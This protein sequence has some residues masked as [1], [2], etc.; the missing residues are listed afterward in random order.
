M[1]TFQRLILLFVF[2]LP[3]FLPGTALADYAKTYTRHRLH[4]NNQYYSDK[5]SACTA[6]VNAKRASYPGENIQQTS[7]SDTTVQAQGWSAGYQY[8]SSGIT[9]YG[10]CNGV[11]SEWGNGICT[12]SCVAPQ[13]LQ[14]DGTCAVPPPPPCTEGKVV[15]DDYTEVNKSNAVGCLN[16]CEYYVPYSEPELDC[17]FASG[18][19]GTCKYLYHTVFK[20][21]GIEC[22]GNDALPPPVD[23]SPP[24]CEACK[25]ME[26]GGAWGTVNG[27]NTCVPQGS[28][29][30]PPVTT[31]IPPQVKTETPPPT[32]ENPNPTPVTTTTNSNVNVTITSNA[33]GDPVI[34]TETTNADGS[35]T[36]TSATKGQ[37]CAAN[38][39]AE[40]CGG[41]GVGKN[42]SYNGA[43]NPDGTVNVQCDGDAIQCAI[44]KQSAELNC[45]L[46]PKQEEVDAY[47]AA[48]N[49]QL[50]DLPSDPTKRTVINVPET[51]DAT[52]PFGAACPEDMYFTLN[53][54]QF[55]LPISTWCPY[56]AWLGNVFLALAYLYGARAL[57][58]SL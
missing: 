40:L 53:G 13:T 6:F 15:F 16:G 20:E 44:A 9:K 23:P 17:D 47:T 22:S 4:F 10:S 24:T 34:T 37:Y 8:Y 18:G 55:T 5:Q 54:H 1:A 43:C 7:C 57:I 28:P 45:S 56:L 50:T 41:D 2:V 36:T 3:A 29:G 30:A 21:S 32:A 33:N 11:E 26:K 19:V 25:C 48:K 52:T 31:P 14:S 12:G 42:N 51:L 46:Q 58:G 39:N 49:F 38:P 27:I 35:K